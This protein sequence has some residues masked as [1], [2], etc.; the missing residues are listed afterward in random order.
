MAPGKELSPTSAGRCSLRR[1]TISWRGRTLQQYMNIKFNLMFINNTSLRFVLTKDIVRFGKWFVQPC[2]SSDRLFG[3]RYVTVMKS[4]DRDCS[5]ICLNFC[6]NSENCF[7]FTIWQYPRIM[8]R[9]SVQ[10]H[11]SLWHCIVLPATFLNYL[12]LL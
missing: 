4:L 3:R 7:Q 12:I 2:T 10:W 1:C 11:W 9:N 6:E 5:D 8:N